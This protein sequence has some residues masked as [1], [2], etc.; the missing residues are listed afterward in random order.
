MLP[1]PSS[2]KGIVE[3]AWCASGLPDDMVLGDYT[4]L[5]DI[6]PVTPNEELSVMQP[7]GSVTSVTQPVPSATLTSVMKS[8]PTVCPLPRSLCRPLTS[9]SSDFGPSWNGVSQP[10]SL[11]LVTSVTQ[12]APLNMM[13]GMGDITSPQSAPSILETLLTAHSSDMLTSRN[14]C[15][16]HCPHKPGIMCWIKF[17]IVSNQEI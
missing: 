17:P 12:T 14:G 4:D 16:T 5:Y 3:A 10:E 15:I 6:Q 11:S 2:L 9:Q 7:P 13:T 8:V 1:M